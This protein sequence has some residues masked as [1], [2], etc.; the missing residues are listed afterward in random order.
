MYT[1]KQVN[2]YASGQLY[3]SRRFPN[4]TRDMLIGIGDVE[5]IDELKYADPNVW[6][7]MIKRAYLEKNGSLSVASEDA[8]AGVDEYAA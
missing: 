3:A 2:C 5:L 1:G 8:L 7:A 6:R 4:S